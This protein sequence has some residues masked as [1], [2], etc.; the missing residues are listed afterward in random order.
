M[1]TAIPTVRRFARDETMTTVPVILRHL[2]DVAPPTGGAF[3][4]RPWRTAQITRP[5]VG[6]APVG[7][8]QLVTGSPPG[9]DPAEP[10]ASAHRKMTKYLT[11]RPDDEVTSSQSP[12]S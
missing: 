6:K 8:D 11:S 9:G 7:E 2:S 10:A 3:V 5:G 4:Y 1:R 12:P